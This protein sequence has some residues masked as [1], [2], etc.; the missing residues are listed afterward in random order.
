MNLEN[1]DGPS[2]MCVKYQCYARISSPAR[3]TSYDP[4]GEFKTKTYLPEKITISPP[5]FR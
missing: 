5:E 4:Q 3:E 2:D 1:L